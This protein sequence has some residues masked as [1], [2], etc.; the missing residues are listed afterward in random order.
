MWRGVTVSRHGRQRGVIPL[1]IILSLCTLYHKMYIVQGLG[2]LASV[3]IER[4]NQIQTVN[5]TVSSNLEL[6]IQKDSNK[7]NSS[8]V[9]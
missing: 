5:L 7:A 2:N 1:H 8:Y 4:L 9:I 3:Y 6:Y